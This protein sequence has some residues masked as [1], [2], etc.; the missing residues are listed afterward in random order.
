MYTGQMVFSQL[1]DF[2][3][4]HEFDK[5]R[6]PVS[7][8]LPNAQVPHVWINSA[9]WLSLS[10]PTGTA[11]G[12]SKLVFAPWGPNFIMPGSVS[13]LPAIPWLSPT[14]NATGGSTP[15]SLKC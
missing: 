1:M 8:Q 11:F 14:Q 3:P 15:T 10:S 12:I 2:L 4:K 9:V 7:R 5:V 13:R 6:S